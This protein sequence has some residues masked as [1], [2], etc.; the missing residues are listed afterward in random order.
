MLSLTLWL[1]SDFTLKENLHIWAV[2]FLNSVELS[3]DILQGANILLNDQ[4][5]VKL[6]KESAWC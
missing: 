1:E 5:E 4:G 6:G 3:S 2:E